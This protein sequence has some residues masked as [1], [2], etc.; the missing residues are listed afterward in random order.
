[1]A[2]KSHIARQQRRERIVAQY[3]KKE[4]SWKKRVTMQD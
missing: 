1:M 3:A 2:K 4:K